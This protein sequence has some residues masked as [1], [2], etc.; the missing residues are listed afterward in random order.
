MLHYVKSQKALAVIPTPLVDGEQITLPECHFQKSGY[1]S[2][3][4]G[5]ESQTDVVAFV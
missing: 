3:L 1:K 5:K 4:N 2:T